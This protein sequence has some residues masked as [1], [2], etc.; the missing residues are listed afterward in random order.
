MKYI[1]TQNF[2]HGDTPRIGVLVTNLG[3]PTAPEKGALRRY[4]K[5]FLSDPRVVEIPRLLWWLILNIVILNLRPARS[6]RSYASVWTEAGSPLMVNTQA[7]AQALQ[8]AMNDQCG[9]RVTVDFAMRYGSPSIPE[10][11]Q[12]LWDQ[13]VR[14]LLVLP[15]YPQYS[16]STTAST[17]DALSEDFRRRRWLPELHFV[18]QYFDH[19]AYITAV[20]DSIRQHWQ[21]HP[22]ADKLVFSYHGEPQR[23]LDQGDPYHCQCLKT[24]RLVAQKL[25]LEE[26]QYLTGFQSRF[27]RAEWLKPYLDQ[28]LKALPEQACQSV[29]VVCPGFSSDCLETLEEIAVENRDYFL[30]AGGQRFEYIPCLNA[31]PGHIDALQQIVM[32]PLAHWL[33]Q[34]QSDGNSQAL[35]RQL[36]AAQ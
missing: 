20:A 7:Q 5:Q 16:C 21:H 8:Q 17:F 27:G 31:Q 15:L 13:G 30:A 10:A 35:A 6:A 2:N 18:T 3:T 14:Q 36:G 9:D 25:G 34:P 23:Y 19:P 12:S 26:H 1:G 33:N 28:T 11:L 32:E 29:Q 4:L 24:S 22:Q